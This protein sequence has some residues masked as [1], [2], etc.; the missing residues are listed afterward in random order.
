MFHSVPLKR[1]LCRHAR[2][3]APGH[4][5]HVVRSLNGIEIAVAVVHEGRV[6]LHDT[7]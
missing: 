6:P 1:A 4:Q 5:D 7:R 2:L 3:G